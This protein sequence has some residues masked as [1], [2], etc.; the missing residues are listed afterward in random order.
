MTATRILVTGGAGFVGSHVVDLLVEAGHEVVVLDSLVAHGDRPPRGCA[1]TSRS[2]AA[3][4]AI[5][6]RGARPPAA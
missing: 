1:G 6:R 3:T 4:C 5:P 2:C